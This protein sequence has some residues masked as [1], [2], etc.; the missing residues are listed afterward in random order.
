[1]LH[2]SPWA[3]CSALMRGAARHL[4]PAGLLLTYGPYFIEGQ[5]AA[6]GNIAFD[7]DLRARNPAWGIR[8]LHEVA[9]AAQDAGLRLREQ[10]AMPANNLT[11][12][13]ERE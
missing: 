3:T 1:M 11:L 9:A 4:S 2:I 8:W 13:F 6:P 12:V 10:I 7:A 5:A